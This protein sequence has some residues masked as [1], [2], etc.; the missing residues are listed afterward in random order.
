MREYFAQGIPLIGPRA[1][2]L[3]PNLLEPF[4]A[5]NQAYI[6][7]H[8]LTQKV[9]TAINAVCKEKPEEPTAYLVRRA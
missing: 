6:D 5:T 1:L 4:L 9:E 3:H 2:V 8:A 7:A